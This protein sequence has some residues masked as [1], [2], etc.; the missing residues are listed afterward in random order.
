M[1][2]IY[3]S[4]IIPAFNEERRI[5]ST[6]EATIEYLSKQSFSWEILVMDDG[7]TDKTASLVRTFSS[8]DKRVKLINL[9]HKGK[10]VAVQQGMLQAMGAYRFFA[11]ADLSMPIDQFDRFYPR[12]I[13]DF[14]IAIA[15]REIS[16]A[17]RL[18]EPKLRYIMGRAFNLIT[19]LFALK[20]IPDTQCGFKLFRGEIAD[21]LFS[22]QRTQGFSFDIEIL[23]LAQKSGLNII[24]IP[25]DWYYNGDSKV[26]RFRDAFLMIKDIL[27]IRFNYFLGKYK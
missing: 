7:S 24:Q 19:R 15:S 5:Y 6:L 4:F 2:S 14:D 18:K 16:G 13:G 26:Q 22:V 1:S 10:G 17:R 3:L 11:D 25:I 27:I 21:R 9:P 12:L 8:S 23:F 20:G